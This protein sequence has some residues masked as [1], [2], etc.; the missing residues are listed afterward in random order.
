MIQRVIIQKKYDVINLFKVLWVASKASNSHLAKIFKCWSEIGLVKP[1]RCKYNVA[2][3]P[4][5]FAPT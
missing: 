2:S 5:T 1:Q 3:F 4:I